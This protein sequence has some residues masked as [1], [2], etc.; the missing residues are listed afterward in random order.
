M[1]ILIG[2]LLS[3]LIWKKQRRRVNRLTYNET[4][5]LWVLPSTA[6][7]FRFHEGGW[8]CSEH[9]YYGKVR[10]FFGWS[11]EPSS[12]DGIPFVEVLPKEALG[13]L[14]EAKSL[15][16]IVTRYSKLYEKQLST[17]RLDK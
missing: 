15:V 3:Q 13:T 17:R 2:S 4:N 9:V 5:A 7:V 14:A 6:R 10:G 12:C 8:Q 11:S 1:S 16:R